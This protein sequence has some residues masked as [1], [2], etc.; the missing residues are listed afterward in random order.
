M[1][2]GALQ[3]FGNRPRLV[4]SR[5]GLV[6]GREATVVRKARLMLEKLAQSERATCD[7]AI[8]RQPAITDQR[9]GSGGKY[10]LGEAPPRHRLIEAMCLGQHSGFYDRQGVFHALI[11]QARQL[12]AMMDKYEKERGS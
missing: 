1:G 7:R 4:S 10:R 12:I 9:Q 5:H 11:Y 6:I 8:E 2:V 3:Q